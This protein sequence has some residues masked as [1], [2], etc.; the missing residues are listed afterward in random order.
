MNGSAGTGVKVFDL[1][2]FT[3]V[4]VTPARM[5]LGQVSMTAG[6]LS[7]ALVIVVSVLLF[8]AAGKV[9]QMMSLYK[10]TRLN[11]DRSGRC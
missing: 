6:F 2:P 11:P 10:G 9:Y 3:A 4:M 1:I 8:M 5:L 7:L